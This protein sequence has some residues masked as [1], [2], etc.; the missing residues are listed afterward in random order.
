M[1]ESLIIKNCPEVLALSHEFSN[2]PITKEQAAELKTVIII[3]KFY[4]KNSIIQSL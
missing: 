2:I 4:L 1:N 3:I